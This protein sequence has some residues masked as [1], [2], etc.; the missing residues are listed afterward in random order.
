LDDAVPT[1]DDLAT[2]PLFADLD[3]ASRVKLA[4]L[5][6]VQEYGPGKQLVTEGDSGYTFYVIAEGRVATTQG[7]KH[8]G[9][10][11]AGDFFGEIAIMGEEGRRTATVTA[12]T[13]VVAWL[14]FG[15][16]FRTL[17]LK[18]PHVS[19]SLQTAMSRRLGGPR[20]P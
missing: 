4:G 3:D 20:E 18:E 7:D 16:S 19:A 5:F 1:G 13:P 14:M 6:E 10:L 15:A 17:Q 12:V 11:E 2:I 8:L 9:Y